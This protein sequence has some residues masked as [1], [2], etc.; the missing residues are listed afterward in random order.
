MQAPVRTHSFT[1]IR[2]ALAAAVVFS[3]SF[4]RCGIRADPLDRWS[5]GQLSC[6]RLAVIGFF[7]ISGFLLSQSLQLN[8]S[9]LRYCVHRAARILPGYWLALL[10]T[11]FVLAPMLIYQESSGVLS[12]W[13]MLRLGP[14][15]ALG[16][17]AN[18]WSLHVGQE[19]ISAVFDKSTGLHSI[20]GSLWTLYHE[21]MCYAGLLLLWTFRGLRAPVVLVLWSAVYGLHILDFA[22]HR[23]FIMISPLAASAGHFFS[24]ATFRA[25]YLAFLSGMLVCQFGLHER[26]SRVWFILAVAA[27]L[28]SAPS[29]L[30]TIVWPLTLPWILV[31]GAHRWPAGRSTQQDDWSYGLY[32]YTFP[33]QQCLA[34]GGLQRFGVVP[35]FIVSLLLGSGAGALSWRLVESPVLNWARGRLKKELP[36]LALP[37]ALDLA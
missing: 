5:G 8:P 2:L 20:N 15:T 6:G 12:Y 14:N 37:T 10:L 13:E 30:S 9:L 16:Y 11:C 28:A 31:S 34:L 35:F 33:L 23:A 26:G 29:H 17:V 21:A 18:N 4:A 19:E 7:A 27:L 3:H 32:I 36:P 25:L 1:F 24:I 22:D